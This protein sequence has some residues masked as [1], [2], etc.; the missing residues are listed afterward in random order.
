MTSSLP[1][2]AGN[3]FGIDLAGLF[4]DNEDGGIPEGF[5]PNFN[6]TANV[7]GRSP[8]TLT[9]KTP[10]IPSGTVEFSLTPE[11]PDI[12]NQPAAPVA[13]APAPAPA[14]P[15]A[16]TYAPQYASVFGGTSAPTY[17]PPTALP[18][19]I[20]VAAAPVTPAPTTPADTQ[21]AAQTPTKPTY[22]SGMRGQIKAAGDILTKKEAIRIAD[23]TGKTVAQVM[24][25]AQDLGTY[26]GS[27]LVNAYSKGKLGPNASN[28]YGDYAIGGYSQGVTKA[29]QNLAPLENLQLPK[30]TAYA[31]SSKYVTPAISTANKFSGSTY[32]PASTVY[33]PIV[34]QREPTKAQ[35]TNI[36]QFNQGGPAFGAGAVNKALSSGLTA[37]EIRKAAS[38][39]GIDLSKKAKQA[40]KK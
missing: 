11:L 37:G 15:A 23:T 28:L 29:L 40:L 12:I 25:K 24:S 4:K 2:F 30:N 34:I 38:A 16:P 17:T 10:K 8:G 19:P 13:P 7:K 36:Q 5:M 39:Q 18:Q 27:G 21:P 22:G 26:L 14:A 31:G 1:Q 35:T 9:Y 20:P 32:T 33:N 6:F 3:L